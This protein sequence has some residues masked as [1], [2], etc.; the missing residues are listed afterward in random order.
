MPNPVLFRRLEDGQGKDAR[1]SEGNSSSIALSERVSPESAKP[2]R[3]RMI[4]NRGPYPQ[5]RDRIQPGSKHREP[6]VVHE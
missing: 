2:A 1:T 4:E 6:R 5:P 3:D